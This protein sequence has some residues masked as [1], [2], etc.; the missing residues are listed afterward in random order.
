MVITKVLG[1][2]L[3][4]VKANYQSFACICY[5]KKITK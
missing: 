3:D 5:K 2:V 4:M 1:N